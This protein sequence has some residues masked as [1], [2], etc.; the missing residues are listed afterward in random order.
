MTFHRFALDRAA[1][2]HCTFAA[3]DTGKVI[4]VADV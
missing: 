1:E 4:F 2:A 3:G